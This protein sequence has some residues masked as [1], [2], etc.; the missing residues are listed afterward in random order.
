MIDAAGDIIA[1]SP[2][3]TAERPEI[4]GMFDTLGRAIKEAT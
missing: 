2:P 1:L 3:L 4:D